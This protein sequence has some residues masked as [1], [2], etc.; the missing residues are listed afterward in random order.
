MGIPSLVTS[1]SGKYKVRNVNKY[2]GK[3]DEKGEIRYRSRWEKQVMKT[4][5]D[6][7]N[8]IRWANELFPIMYHH[9][10]EDRWA[11]YWPDF[12]VMLR[13]RDGTIVQGLIEVKPKMQTEAPRKLKRRSRKSLIEAAT[14]GQNNAKWDAAKAFCD[15]RGW[16]FK[17]MTE[18][19]IFK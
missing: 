18:E 12:Y 19:D 15:E 1:Y 16:F 2:V 13:K 3:R 10:I 6:N 7:P 17:I 11:N 5:D 4:L 14:F 9:P 8:V